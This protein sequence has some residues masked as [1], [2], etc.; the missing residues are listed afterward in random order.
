MGVGGQ[1]KMVYFRARVGRSGKNHQGRMT[2]RVT[3]MSPLLQ[4]L[5]AGSRGIQRDRQIDRMIKR[6]TQL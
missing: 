5:Q 3:K 2:K 6:H 1:P 4:R